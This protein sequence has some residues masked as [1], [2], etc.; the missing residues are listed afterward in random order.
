[1][2][3]MGYCR[4]ENT[5]ADLRD[6]QEWLSVHEI[7]E[8]SD[9][10]EEAFRLLVRHCRRI[11]ENLASL[12]YGWAKECRIC[13]EIRQVAKRKPKSGPFANPGIN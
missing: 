2:S 12:S 13:G 9:S 5:L 4:F 8:L 1:M 3:N 10:E 11:A 7:S 6:C